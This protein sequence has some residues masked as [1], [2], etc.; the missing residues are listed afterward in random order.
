MYCRNCG[1]PSKGKRY[2]TR[3]GLAQALP[4][5]YGTPGPAKELS[6]GSKLDDK[7]LLEERLGLGGMGIVYRAQR[8]LIGDRVALKVLHPHQL[9]DARAIARFQ[10]EAQAIAR[11]RHVG[12]ATLFDFGTTKDGL[13]YLA[14]ELAEGVSL[15]EWLK[16]R[17]NLTEASAV[18]IACQLCEVL[19]AAH[20][21][22]IIHRD[23]KPENIL[24]QKTPA[25]LR[26]KLLDFGIAA[27]NETE[28]SKLT[29]T[30]GVL[31]T[32]QYMAPEQCLGEEM[33]GRADLYSLGIVLY[34]MLC[35]TTPFAS[36][37]T[38]AIIVH[39]VNQKP[40]PVRAHNPAVS[41]ALEAV[42][43]RA[44]AKQ[45][46]ARPQ[47]AT[48][49]AQELRMAHN[50]G[51]KAQTTSATS[52]IAAAVTVIQELPA[53]VTSPMA[54][55]PNTIINAVP[56]PKAA[57]P[58]KPGI[59]PL[60]ALRHPA[61][62][63]LLLLL[64]AS[65]FFIRTFKSEA[66]SAQA[67][68]VMTEPVAVVAT[69]ALSPVAVVQNKRWEVITDQTQLTSAVENIATEADGQ[70]AVLAPGGQIALA[71][72]G[73]TAFNNG[74]GADLQL[75]SPQTEA[76]SYS[77]WVRNQTQDAWQ[78]VDVSHQGFSEGTRGHD[79]GHH[80]IRTA[81]Q[82]LIRNEA[83]QNFVLDAVTPVYP[84]VGAN[85]TQPH[86]HATAHPIAQRD[87]VQSRSTKWQRKSAQQTRIQRQF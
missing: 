52:T 18:E 42:I 38:T 15:R 77:V 69:P 67:M 76:V 31:G 44:L 19:A 61:W 60:A 13:M 29:H 63:F 9:T 20:Q 10:R 51:V 84:V 14:M 46:S 28:P 35:G 39:Q 34:E 8:L 54:T 65:A 24:V 80:G 45:P 6:A 68:G 81:R 32:P 50:K 17:G 58:R 30:G 12:I 3:C 40:V 82:V 37:I 2:C 86:V 36:A 73:E 41:P 66:P 83:R 5:N 48:A 16:Q 21:Q 49:F 78:R 27:L 23:L 4:Q 55:L 85:D 47:T 70:V 59:K 62:T 71:W 57:L 25:G 72:Q 64:A 79:M 43:L 1:I 7:Y 11:L 22:Q 87:L 75:H 74:A 33:D 53:K 26:I 56:V